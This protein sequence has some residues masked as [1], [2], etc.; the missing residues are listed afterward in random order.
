MVLI[1]ENWFDIDPK[2]HGRNKCA[3]TGIKTKIWDFFLYRGIRNKKLKKTKNIQEWVAFRFCS[4]KGIT[5]SR[6]ECTYY[7]APL[8]F[9]CCAWIN[10]STNLTNRNEADFHL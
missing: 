2:M 1:I 10:L 5:H 8:P 9:F 7:I 6:G 4:V 3:L